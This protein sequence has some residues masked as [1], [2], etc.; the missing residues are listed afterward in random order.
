MAYTD[1]VRRRLALLALLVAAAS[2][3]ILSAAACAEPDVGD[4]IETPIVLPDRVEPVDARDSAPADAGDAATD[5]FVPDADAGADAGL[6][7]F[8][9]ST[10]RNANLGGLP[11]GD[12]ICQGLATDAGLGGTWAAWLSNNG[13]AGPHAI[14][15]VTSAGPWRLVTGEIVAANKTELASGTLKHAIDRDEKGAA[16]VGRVWTGTGADGRYLTNDCDKWTTGGSGR[17]GSSTGSDAT[18]TSVAVDDC[19]N[20]RRLYCFQL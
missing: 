20:V 19:G 4:E 3:A 8:V 6:R 13:G 16:V 2:A 11:G 10:A 7:V 12:A 5:A 15:R 1:P 17:V 18:W 14:D 9:S